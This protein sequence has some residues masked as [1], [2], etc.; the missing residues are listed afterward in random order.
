MNDNTLTRNNITRFLIRID[1]AQNSIEFANVAN[2]LAPFFN[3]LEKRQQTHYDVNVDEQHISKGEIIDYVLINDSPFVSVILSKQ[4]NAILFDTNQ[5]K[6]NSVYRDF[7]HQI[8]N[9]LKK[10]YP[11]IDAK[12]IGMRFI[13]EFQCKE[14]KFISK[15]F[16]S[17]RAK[18]I[19]NIVS[20]EDISRII[21]QE[22]FNF[23]QSKI[24]IQYGVPNKFYP[25]IL[26]N[27][28]LLLDIDSFDDSTHKLDDWDEV[29]SVLNHRAYEKFINFINPKFL[30]DLK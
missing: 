7:S 6:D 23:Q 10:I 26:N 16:E 2:N 24:R 22:E 9:I 20:D 28:D 21:M 18:A 8:I 25:S 4:M 12:R 5:Y 19:G 14:I 29:L 15:I 27:Y 3:R 11:D 17:T 30:E 13:N 1:L